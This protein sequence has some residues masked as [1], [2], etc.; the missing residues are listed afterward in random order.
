M[1]P[2]HLSKYKRKTLSYS[3]NERRFCLH[4]ESGTHL[5][6][7]DIDVSGAGR[8]YF[9][10]VYEGDR[11]QGHRSAD[12][13][14]VGSFHIPGRQIYFVIVVELEGHT[15]FE[16][17]AEQVRSTL[18]HFWPRS[19]DNTLDDDGVRHHEQARLK[20]RPYISKNDHLVVGIVVGSTGRRGQLTKYKEWPIICL[21]SRQP[22]QDKTPMALFEEIA[23]YTGQRFW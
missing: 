12:G 6:A 18:E 9:K 20:P 3:E 19:Q 7:Y 10:D 1:P 2:I 22:V 13:I 5:R 11:R 4:R 23:S 8:Q 14:Y 21:N 15:S 16:D 17:S